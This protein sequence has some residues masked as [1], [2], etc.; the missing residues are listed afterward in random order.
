MSNSSEFLAAAEAVKTFTSRPTDAELLDLYGYF[1]QASIGDVNTDRPGMLDFKGKAKWDN[2]ESR[3]GMS[4]E[5][6]EKS[7]IELVERLKGQYSS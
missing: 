5:A 3:K 6:A 7:Y 4:K 1:K 2:W